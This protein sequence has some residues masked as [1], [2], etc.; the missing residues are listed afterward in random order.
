[1]TSITILGVLHRQASI[2]WARF[3]PAALGCRD[4]LSG[5]AQCRP[6]R[7]RRPARNYRK[8]GFKFAYRNIRHQSEGGGAEPSGLLYLPSVAFDEIARYDGTVFPSARPSFLRLWIRQPQGAAFGVQGKQNLG[9]RRPARMP[10]GFQDR[11]A[12]P[13]DPYIAGTLFQGLASRVPGQPI[14]LESPEANPAAIE[15]AKRHGMEPVFE[16]APRYQ[17]APRW[18]D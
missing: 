16:T 17:W 18:A 1:M 6:G 3:W 11:A 12:L 9:I 7:R 4:G 8:S 13:N 2:S 14:F 15:L 10:P 5:R